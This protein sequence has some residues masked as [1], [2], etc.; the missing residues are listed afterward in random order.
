MG[1]LVSESGV[2]KVSVFRWGALGLWG[3]KTAFMCSGQEDE[4][5]FQ[6][7]FVAGNDTMGQSKPRDGGLAA[8]VPDN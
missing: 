2:R 8:K 6:H 1:G 5:L 4:A 7:L 3:Q